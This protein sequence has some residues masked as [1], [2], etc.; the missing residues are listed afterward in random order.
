MAPFSVDRVAVIGAGSMGA[1]IAGL[2]ANVGIDC[3]LT[4][5][6]TEIRRI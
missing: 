6:D 1:Q 3:D 2:L 5:R 4:V